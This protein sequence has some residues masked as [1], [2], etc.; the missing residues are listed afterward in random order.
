MIGTDDLGVSDVVPNH[1]QEGGFALG[2]VRLC[3]H[4]C[5][6]PL[7]FTLFQHGVLVTHAALE[8]I[9]LCRETH[10]VFDGP[11]ASIAVE[12]SDTLAGVV[13]CVTVLS[14]SWPLTLWPNA[15]RAPAGVTARL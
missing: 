14:P 4:R 3:F 2:A 5:H 1:A 8:L 13:R 10:D 12:I 9:E 6:P 7:V 15:K 11:S